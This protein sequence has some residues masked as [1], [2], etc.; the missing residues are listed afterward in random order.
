MDKHPFHPPLGLGIVTITVVLLV[1]TLACFAM[2][3]VSS[4]RADYTLS[5]RNADTVAEYYA[6]DAQAVEDV[7]TFLQSEKEE[8]REDIPV[9]NYGILKLHIRRSD[10]GTADILSWSLTPAESNAYLEETDL[11]LWTGIPENA[12]E[13]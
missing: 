2:L 3:T 6:A 9:G 5:Q 11:N 1:I 7:A 10:N 8:L 4:A 12:L 13:N